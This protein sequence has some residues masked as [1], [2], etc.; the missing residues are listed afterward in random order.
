MSINISTSISVQQ[1]LSEKHTFIDQISGPKK[2]DIKC[3][4]I[5]VNCASVTSTRPNLKVPKIFKLLK[6]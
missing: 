1:K 4:P 6:L 5:I 3:I 2:A